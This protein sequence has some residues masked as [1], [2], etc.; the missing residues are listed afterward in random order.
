[1]KKTNKILVSLGLLTL[2]GTMTS[3]R[4]PDDGKPNFSYKLTKFDNLF[5]GSQSQADDF[6]D[7]YYLT[8]NNQD[9]YIKLSYKKLDEETENKR[10]TKFTE[11]E[12]YYQFKL[13]NIENTFDKQTFIMSNQ[14][15]KMY[16]EEYKE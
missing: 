15:T 1:M 11:Y 14:Y 13:D 3:C 6:Y 16:F 7:Y 9:N 8:I 5:T 10:F 4:Q 2:C 12:E